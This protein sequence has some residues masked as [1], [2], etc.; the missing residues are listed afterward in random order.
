MRSNVVPIS[1]RDVKSDLHKAALGYA[2]RGFKIFPCI[3]NE[4]SKLAAKKDKKK[5]A[6][7]HGLRDATDDP[8]QINEW[9]T[10]DPNFNIG[11]DP[12]SVGR[13]V[14]DTE[15][16]V[17]PGWK[18]E[19]KLLKTFTV[20]TPNG[21]KHRHYL[22]ELRTTTGTLAPRVDTRGAGKGYVLLPPSMIDDKPYVVLDGREPILVPD[23]IVSE[24]GNR[25]KK[26]EALAHVELDQPAN[27]ARAIHHLKS[28]PIATERDGC[29]AKTFA[30]AAVCRD[31]G[32]SL[33][34]CVEIMM[35]H[36]KIA[37]KD[38][39]H[40]AFLGRKVL[41]AYK[42]AENEPG[43]YATPPM[44]ETFGEAVAKLKL[45]PAPKRSRFFP[46][47]EEEMNNLPPARWIVKDVLQE[48][49][50]ALWVGETQSYKSFMAL[51][52][53]LAIATGTGTFGVKPVQGP[54]FYAALEGLHGVMGDRRKAWRMARG[55]TGKITDFYAMPAP[56][57]TNDADREEFI[58]QIRSRCASRPDGRM[59]V[60]IVLETLNKMLDG[61]Q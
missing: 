54:T 9:W 28:L 23:W 33:E 39:R 5:P 51:E 35:E 16:D 7:Q 52:L 59:P 47:G 4:Q 1:K 46:L 41:N 43:A 14:L 17:D 21:G 26:A 13:C 37:P 24:L 60:L 48:K 32:V 11:F 27:V 42:Y 22:G 57:V 61:L 3:S 12:H 50:T 40:E 2:Q 30:A 6:C 55:I 20:Q 10:E 36:F 34:K 31:L 38:E 53:A 58:D 49:K 29:D 8:K 19:N 56:T 25:A 15:A 45:E 44:A 18:G